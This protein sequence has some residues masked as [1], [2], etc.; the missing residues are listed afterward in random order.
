[1][2]RARRCRCRVGRI[3]AVCRRPPPA[4]L[5]R[6][7]LAI[8]R[9]FRFEDTVLVTE[10]DML[11]ERLS[12]PPRRRANYD[13]FV[14]EVATLQPGDVVVHAEHGIGR[15]DGL[16]TLEVGGAPHDCLRVIYSGD[17]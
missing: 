1:M 3:S 6:A 2:A 14:A 4:P 9:G 17:D 7:V 16:A 15:Y 12:R 11:G 8:E 5:A 13:Q 10:Q